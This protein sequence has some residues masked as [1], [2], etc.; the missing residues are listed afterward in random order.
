VLQV[1]NLHRAKARCQDD[2]EEDSGGFEKEDG[3]PGLSCHGLSFTKVGEVEVLRRWKTSD[4]GELVRRAKVAT[5]YHLEEE[6]QSSNP[7]MA[8]SL[9]QLCIQ[10]NLNIELK[11]CRI[12]SESGELSF[13]AIMESLV[14][15]PK[16]V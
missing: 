6:T 16:E 14:G 7:V 3:G 5:T 15:W 9:V 11:G 4:A 8:R 2:Q 13:K 12:T 1:R 10:A